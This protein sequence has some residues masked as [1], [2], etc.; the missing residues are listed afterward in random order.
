MAP[1]REPRSSAPNFDLGRVAAHFDVGVTGREIEIALGLLDRD[2][3]TARRGGDVA[4]DAGDRDHSMLGLEIQLSAAGHVQHGDQVTSYV[5]LDNPGAGDVD[6][7][8]LDLA[9][10]LDVFE[11]RLGC[12]LTLGKSFFGDL[13]ANLVSRERT[14]RNGTLKKID[15]DLGLFPSVEVQGLLRL[16]RC[17]FKL[18]LFIAR[19]AL[20][21]GWVSRAGRWT[22]G[23]L[24]TERGE[25]KCR[26][27]QD[28]PETRP[29]HGTVLA[30]KNVNRSPQGLTL[31]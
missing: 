4:R 24:T 17:Q 28:Q 14:D 6:A 21:A 3:G 11:V 1:A 2:G 29:K 7:I 12:F 8:L 20:G 18:W 22:P 5:L 13:K 10:D 15:D 9:F 26:S 16:G 27:Q 30:N 23:G 19:W 31:S 25:A